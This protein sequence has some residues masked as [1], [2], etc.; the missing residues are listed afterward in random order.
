MRSV[1][2]GRI[3]RARFAVVTR[4]RSW[5]R[6]SSEGTAQF[7]PD[8]LKLLSETFVAYG[9]INLTD[10]PNDQLPELSTS[11]RMSPRIVYK[12]VFDSE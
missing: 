3:L 5:D 2:T 12:A 7:T 8:T 4:S 10:V 1:A 6:I 11:V 9:S